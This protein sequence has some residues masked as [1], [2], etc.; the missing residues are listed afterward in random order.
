V[1]RI[2]LASGEADGA[3][4][5]VLSDDELEKLELDPREVQE[6]REKMKIMAGVRGWRLEVVEVEGDGK[7]FTGHFD[8]EGDEAEEVINQSGDPDDDED[9]KEKTAK[10]EL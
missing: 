10:D 3:E 1:E 4:M 6:L 2:T 5:T 7:E 8:P 9:S